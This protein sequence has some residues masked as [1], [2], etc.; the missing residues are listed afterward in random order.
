MALG[1]SKAFCIK[2]LI[3][4][5][6]V[7]SLG[8]AFQS[9]F[10]IGIDPQKTLSM[11]ARIFLIDLKQTTP[12]K[13]GI[14]VFRTKGLSPVYEDG[15]EL[16]KRVA[17]QPGDVVEITDNFDVLVNDEQIGR[18]MWHL[19]NADPDEIRARF[20]GKYVV[21]KGEYW[22][23]GESHESFDSRYFGVIEAEQ[24]KGRA[25]AIF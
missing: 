7:L 3:A 2:A 14:Y 12:E 20:S 10:H 23:S 21:G 25:Y 8:Y 24:I 13:G 9:R 19:R 1:L 18:G 5:S 17:A 15:T 22:M 4:V 11:N 16:V 6:A